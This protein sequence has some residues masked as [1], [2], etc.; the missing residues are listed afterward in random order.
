MFVIPT[1][2]STIS[3]NS[4]ITEPVPSYSFPLLNNKVLVYDDS[5]V[6]FVANPVVPYVMTSILPRSLNLN[7]DKRIHERYTKHFYFK[8]IDD[9]LYDDMSDLLTYFKYDRDS[10]KVHVL[11][12]KVSERGDQ[13][14][15]DAKIKF[16][17]DSFFKK[18]DMYFI[19]VKLI[20]ESHVNWY[21]LPKLESAV[22]EV[23][24]TW[25]RKEIQRK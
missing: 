9:W 13:E 25:F 3:F 21:D 5:P 4:V 19:L 2:E 15:A 20:D 16:I 6:Q 12:D 10:K 18:S 7:Y 11:R 24:R 1:T 8:V 14:A 17:E 23:T 22:K